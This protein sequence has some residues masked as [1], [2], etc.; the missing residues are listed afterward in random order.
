MLRISEEKEGMELREKL[1]IIKEE[2]KNKM[3]G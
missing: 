2:Q 1:R 3:K